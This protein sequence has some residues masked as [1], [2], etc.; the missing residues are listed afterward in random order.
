MDK[1]PSE[2]LDFPV[3]LIIAI[4]LTASGYLAFQE[5][6]R[7]FRPKQTQT[8][9]D[10]TYKGVEARLWQD[11]IEVLRDKSKE[12]DKRRIEDPDYKKQFWSNPFWD[13]PQ[14]L[15]EEIKSAYKDKK[16]VL[17]LPVLVPGRDDIND[18]ESRLRCRYAVLSALD[19]AGYIPENADRIRFLNRFEI[20]PREPMGPAVLV[21]GLRI[22]NSLDPPSQDD[23][24]L[25]DYFSF[26]RSLIPY[27]W[28]E[29]DPLFPKAI[30]ANA[31]GGVNTAQASLNAEKIVYDKIL[32][33][34]II[35]EN[36]E[37]K[38]L[39]RISRILGM[40]GW[41]LKAERQGYSFSF[42][43][44][45]GPTDSDGLKR[46]ECL[47][48]EK[49][50]KRDFIKIYS[51]YATAEPRILGW[52]EEMEKR[53]IIRTVTSDRRIIHA[54][55][56]ELAARRVRLYRKNENGAS[57]FQGADRVAL[58]SDWDTFYGR[59][60]PLTFAAQLRAEAAKSSQTERN[61][62]DVWENEDRAFADELARI[63]DKPEAWP[64]NV[65][66]V[67]Y[68]R[69][70]DGKSTIRQNEQTSQGSEKEN[71]KE[72]SERPEGPGQLDYLRRLAERLKWAEEQGGKPVK[73]IGVLGTDV[74][75]KLL[76]LQALREKF[77]YAIFFTTDLDAR[78]L[79]PSQ[80]KWTRNLIIASSFWLSPQL[81]PKLPLYHVSGGKISPPFRD[82]YQTS[83]FFA[84]LGALDLVPD[85]FFKKIPS[86]SI[87]EVG[88]A[89]VHLLEP[90]LVEGPLGALWK[91]RISLALA[92]ILMVAVHLM[93]R[94]VSAT[95]LRL[96]YWL[97]QFL[98]IFILCALTYTLILTHQEWPEPFEVFDGVSVW[99]SVILRMLAGFLGFHFLVKAHY[100][101]SDNAEALTRDYELE[102]GRSE[103][104]PLSSTL[105]RWKRIKFM[106]S[107]KWSSKEEE[108]R[109][110]D[111]WREY[112]NRSQNAFTWTRVT[113]FSFIYIL[114]GFSLFRN[115]GSSPSPFRG[116]ASF[117]VNRLTLYLS[118][119]LLIVLMFYI[120]DVILLCDGFIKRLTEGRSRWPD[121]ITD[122]WGGR[123]SRI[124]DAIDYW[125]DIQ[126]VTR[127]TDVIGSLII[128]PFIVIFVMILSRLSVFDNWS[129]HTALVTVL[130]LHSLVA[131]LCL[132]LLIRSARKSKALILE[133]LKM[134]RLMSSDPETREALGA[135]I[136][137]VKDIKRGAFAP[138]MQQPLI[139]AV[140]V[141]LGGLTT[142]FVQL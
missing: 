118:V 40:V 142:A 117:L 120:V 59:A 37:Q 12:H 97:L 116:E 87:Y 73:A 94:D 21:A 70:L 33:L 49:G 101:L 53:A 22:R 140:L 75:D 38:P 112:R 57:A 2:G 16:K 32:L 51:P 136:Q 52:T 26:I 18:H 127:C 60:L 102:Y 3:Y 65:M 91:W 84:T 1:S 137:E 7:P 34:W 39:Y 78:L 135:I 104:R 48:S 61:S 62:G 54:V 134:K 86:P 99:P 6:F 138:I 76:I 110:K 36:L 105:S 24:P 68:L 121:R 109:V 69:G 123:K 63:N 74:Y 122:K 4:F 58:I 56:G 83:V 28:Y 124:D 55:I 42:A 85:D 29:R 25:P 88:R 11:P 95:S 128:Y 10:I 44:V 130:G 126:M 67:A 141:G 131:L 71:L 103:A 31:Q 108:I 77:K 50:E 82:V 139:R 107:Y 90:A 132:I 64:E 23:S 13:K 79:H 119:V 30:S 111:L 93:R 89:R 43:R 133:K 114:L 80:Y 14:A 66:R 9:Q 41:S 8:V 125:F 15:K 17:L 19:S 129:W 106:L 96:K 113:F 27:E 47:A 100:K 81:M 92:A 20:E 5:P 45:I 72:D 115:F 46:I 35:N 98:F